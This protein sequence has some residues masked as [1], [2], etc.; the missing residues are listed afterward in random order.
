M[1]LF[2]TAKEIAASP[3]LPGTARNVSLRAARE[4]WPFRSR[5]GRGGG[6][7]YLVSALPCPAQ[8]VMVKRLA[9]QVTLNDR[10][11]LCEAARDEVLRAVVERGVGVE[12][13]ENPTAQTVPTIKTR[14]P[15][16][17]LPV[18]QIHAADREMME[19]R[20]AILSEIDR[21][22]TAEGMSATKAVE[23]VAEVSRLG[24]LPERL[25][26]LARAANGSK[27]TGKAA[28]TRRT[29]MRWLG[30]RKKIGVTALARA[31]VE[32]EEIPA[33]VGAFLR[34]WQRPTKP[35]MTAAIRA[36]EEK[37]PEITPPSIDQTR[38]FVREKLGRVEAMRGRMGPRELKALRSYVIRD[39]SDLLAGDVF[40]ADGH[41]F[42]AEVAHPLTGK[43]FRPEITTI[44]DV[45]TRKV[46]GWSVGLSESADAVLDAMRVA[47]ES[48]G[49]PAIFYTD[50]G[51]GYLNER[52][53]AV[54]DGLGIT[55]KVSLPYNSQ[56]RGVIERF[57]GT[58]T[59]AAKDLVTYMGKPMDPEAKKKVYK[60]TR[61]Q[62]REGD[63]TGI[64][65]GWPDFVEGIKQVVARYN[66]TP[67]S[68]LPEALNLDTGRVE[69]QSPGGAWSVAIGGG[70]PL[71]PVAPEMM[72]GLYRPGVERQ[73]NRCMVQIFN[74]TYFAKELEEFHGEQAWVEY[75]IHDAHRVWVRELESKRLICAAGWDAN[76]KAYF[77]QDVVAQAR[78]QRAMKLVQR[79]ERMKQDAL[80]D[81]RIAP[82]ETPPTPE[83][84]EFR[85][86]LINNM[87]TPPPR[88]ETPEERYERALGIQ[89]RIEAGEVVSE[90]EREFLEIYRTSS[91]WKVQGRMRLMMANS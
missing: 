40:T 41:Q 88:E 54:C 39:F 25:A 86:K 53:A 75:D 33:W 82:P 56:A 73:I 3:G 55:H 61:R 19:A 58:Y 84:E 6:R 89:A 31:R 78:E 70:V 42:D 30:I 59:A 69:R 49:V 47:L 29:L 45:A 77:P 1:P 36:M 12:V 50:R 28:L 20:A 21:I 8:V 51:N 90:Q 17:V 66:A 44:I 32:R 68:S 57:H 72:G 2:A 91:E 4:S 18:E 7:E 83:L 79:A 71:Y 15:R 27:S 81:G 76:K 67:H 26:A 74:N 23:W 43:P 9:A 38:R 48:H 87:T 80:V 65:I 63:G 22:V 52:V 24:R 60:L 5:E 37:F 14:T 64:M 10:E 35:T 16:P 62:F 11:G 85:Q 34:L 13:V 46:V